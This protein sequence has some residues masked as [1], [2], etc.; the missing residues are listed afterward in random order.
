MDDDREP[1]PDPFDL[2]PV[3][4]VT[5]IFQ[6]DVDRGVSPPRRRQLLSFVDHE[7]VE[8]LKQADQEQ[9]RLVQ[10]VVLT[11]TLNRGV[12]SEVS[13]RISRQV[14]GV[15]THAPRSASE[16]DEN[17]RVRGEHL[18]K[19]GIEPPVRLELFRVGSPQNLVPLHEVGHGYDRCPG[20][21]IHRD[22]VVC[23]V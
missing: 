19:R 3:G 13:F 21:D 4:T 16:R 7:F 12:I 10:G 2:L 5:W 18:L 23:G 20:W 6:T 15:V 11:E 9:R 14:A 1:G 8:A 22:R 17:R